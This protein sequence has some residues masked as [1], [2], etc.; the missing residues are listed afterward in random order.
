MSTVAYAREQSFGDP[1]VAALSDAV[2]GDALTVAI[3][4]LPAEPWGA[5]WAEAVACYALHLILATSGSA[6]S[7]PGP[8][9]AESVGQWSKSYAV[10]PDPMSAGWLA[11]TAYGRRVQSIRRSRVARLPFVVS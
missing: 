7:A 6:S 1:E 8:V 3:A 2:I 9:V 11:S 5:R 4:A 10:P